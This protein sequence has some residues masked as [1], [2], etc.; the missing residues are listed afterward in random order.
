[1]A[2]TT[3]LLF[4][5]DDTYLVRIGIIDKQHRTLINF[6]N[7]F[8]GAAIQGHSDEQIDG[9]LSKFVQYG[10]VHIK[11]EETLMERHQYP[12]YAIHKGEHDSLAHAVLDLRSRF[13]RNEIGL[14]IEVMHFLKDWLAEHILRADKKYATYLNAKGVR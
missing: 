10:R 5:W 9:I 4:P 1:M 3:D 13:R 7:E 2:A 11:L 14:T 6:L 12:D 8:H